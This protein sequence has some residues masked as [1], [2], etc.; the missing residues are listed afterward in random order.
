VP[1]SKILSKRELE[2]LKA[3]TQAKVPF[4]VVGLSA[5]ALQGAPVVTQDIDLWFEDLQ[6]PKLKKVLKKFKASYLPP[7]G[8]SP[9]IF[10]GP[11]LELFDIVLNMH[12]L[13]KFDLEYANALTVPLSKI[14]IRVLPLDRIIKSKEEIRREKDLLVLKPLKDALKAQRQKIKSRSGA[15]PKRPAK[16]IRKKP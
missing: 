2:F 4:L 5:A 15:K 11:G 16:S 13:R 1:E 9:P 8:L 6:D 3:L 7:V 10:V 14:N 12:G